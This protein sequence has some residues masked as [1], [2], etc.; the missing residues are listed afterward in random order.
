MS[1]N[2]KKVAAIIG[3][4]AI[5]VSGVTVYANTSQQNQSNL[6]IELSQQEYQYPEEIKF[7]IKNTGEEPIEF[8]NGAPW[9]IKKKTNGEWKQ[10]EEHMATM[11]IWKLEPGKTKTWTWN[12]ENSKNWYKN[13]EDKTG[14]F[15]ISLKNQTKEFK[16]TN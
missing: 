2:I 15:A 11:Q 12:P 14:T 3:I 7:T 6:K 9:T 10:V 5:L 16:I 13:K 4:L 8:K 1:M